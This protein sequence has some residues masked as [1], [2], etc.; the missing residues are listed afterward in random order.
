M[1]QRMKDKKR[2]KAAALLDFVNCRISEP[3]QAA[4]R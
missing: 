2:R 4:V 1:F 3:P